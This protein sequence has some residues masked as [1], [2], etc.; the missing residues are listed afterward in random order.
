MHPWELAGCADCARRPVCS[1]S[2]NGLHRC[3]GRS[4]HRGR[5]RHRAGA[6]GA[7]PRQRR[8]QGVGG[9][10]RTARGGPRAG[11]AG[12][13]AARQVTAGPGHR[14]QAPLLP[15]LG[16]PCA[17]PPSPS[18]LLFL[19]YFI[20]RCIKYKSMRVWQQFWPCSAYTTHLQSA[21][22]AYSGPS[23]PAHTP[24]FIFRG[25][26]RGQAARYVWRVSSRQA[27]LSR[28]SKAPAFS[29]GTTIRLP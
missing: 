12:S 3:Q 25:R 19:F 16:R 4:R 28:A 26:Q 8:G 21:A 7:A 5:A 27:A 13:G 22:P 6:L 20:F 29:R 17:A 9:V 10:G 1:M 14:S 23:M 15:V 2:V 18:L 11:G 24:A